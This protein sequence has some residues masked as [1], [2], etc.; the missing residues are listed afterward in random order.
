MRRHVLN[1]LVVTVVLL[2][3]AMLVSAQS[4]Q[5]RGSVKLADASGKQTPVSGAII[6][7]WR[8]DMKGDYHTKTNNKGEWVFAGLPFIGHYTVSVSAPGANPWARGEIRPNANQPVEIILSPGDGRKLTETE[9]IAAGKGGAAP[10]SGG[11]GSDNSAAEKAKAEELRKKNEEIN[12]ENEKI[13]NAN[14][15]IGDAFKNG[16][17]T[18]NAGM[19]ADKAN[20]RDEAIKLYGDAIQ[21]YDTGLSADSDHPGAPSLMTNKSVALRMRAVDRYNAA[22]SSKEEAAKT[23]GIDAAKADFAAAA[24]MSTKAV[25]MIK[26]QP[27][28]TDP[29]EQKQKETNKNFALAARAEAMR[30]FAMKVDSSKGPEAATALQEYVAVESDPVK[31]SQ[32]EKNYADMLFQTAGD[33]AGYE[34]AIAEYQKVL[35]KTPD[36]PD[37]LLRLGQAFF[38]VGMLNNN[39]KAK[40]Q[41]AANYLQRYVDKGPDGQLK[42]EAKELI[43]SMKQWDVAPE[44]AKTPPRKRP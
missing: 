22:I 39:D 16:N 12:K 30:L 27:A 21:A 44:K 29:S 18:L 40:Y 4:E 14:K 41:E 3:S 10:T 19:E 9:A 35:A 17:A 33:Q 32:I 28:A 13:T 42:T 37:A 25:E 15:I 43:V 31:K 2:F 1:A 6:D 38:N 20:K 34:K 11:G 36:D 7:V 5:L 23:S 26:K 8:T 24:E